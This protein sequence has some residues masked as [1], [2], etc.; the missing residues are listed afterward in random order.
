MDHDLCENIEPQRAQRARRI[1]DS[2]LVRALRAASRW[3]AL[4][5]VTPSKLITTK[6]TEITEKFIPVGAKQS[7]LCYLLCD[8]KTCLKPFCREFRQNWAISPRRDAIQF[9]TKS[10]EITEK[11]IPVGAKQS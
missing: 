7:W 11:F 4:R 6:S 8:P 2:I 5:A 3:L 9:T 1:L 10:T